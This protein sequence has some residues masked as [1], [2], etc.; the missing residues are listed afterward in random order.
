MKLPEYVDCPVCGK[1]KFKTSEEGDC[2]P[3]CSWC[4]YADQYLDHDKKG[5]DNLLSINELKVE[6]QQKIK[7]NPNYQYRLLKYERGPHPC[8]VCGKY[9]FEDFDSHD[10]CPYCGWEDDC[11]SN[12]EVDEV[13]M[14][15]HG[16][17]ILQCREIY[18]E[19]IKADGNYKWDTGFD[20]RRYEKKR[21]RHPKQKPRY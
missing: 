3:Y 14:A 1:Y 10:I 2:C 13:S 6:Y 7:E 11:R 15:N 18:R 12:E 4:F 21:K 16:H 5:G 19:R 8:P 20:F 17:T 9:T